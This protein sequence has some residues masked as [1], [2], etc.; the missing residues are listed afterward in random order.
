MEQAAPIMFN[1]VEE[2]ERVHI[3]R[4]GKVYRYV[5]LFKGYGGSVLLDIVQLD[6]KN[7]NTGNGTILYIPIK[8]TEK[9]YDF[10]KQVTKP[11]YRLSQWVEV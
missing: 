2:A 7:A 3:R 6:A 4:K 1:S 5:G 10:N 8:T 9:V 11:V